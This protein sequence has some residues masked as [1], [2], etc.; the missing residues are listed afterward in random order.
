MIAPRSTAA[1]T[2]TRRYC[3][4]LRRGTRI[5]AHGRRGVFVRTDRRCG[6]G[7]SV[8]AA[9]LPTADTKPELATTGE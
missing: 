5:A 9:A 2:V 7:S 4:G 3:A 6:I 1:T 8:A